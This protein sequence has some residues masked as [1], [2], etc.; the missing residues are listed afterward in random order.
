MFHEFGWL[1]HSNIRPHASNLSCARIFK[2]DN[3]S[4]TT[5]TAKWFY[6]FLKLLVAKMS[7]INV[8]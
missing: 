7:K 1:K 3:Y 5:D 6:T 2:C 4:R 8:N